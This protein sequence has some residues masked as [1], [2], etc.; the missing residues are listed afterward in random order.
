MTT[1]RSVHGVP[2]EWETLPAL[3]AARAAQHGDL[4]RLTVAGRAMSYRELDDESSLVAANLHRLGVR[5]GDRIACFLRNAPEHLVSWV[6]AGKLG[7]IWVPLNAGLVGEDLVHTL[8][9]AVPAVLVVDE[10]LADRVAAVKEKLPPMRI[11]QTGE[12]KD[13]PA[14]AEL[15]E[16]GAAL[17]MVEV[18]GGDPAVIIYTGGTTGLPKG[19]LLPHFAWIAAG[20][21]YVEAFETRPDD[22]HYSILTLFHVGG[23]MLGVVGPMVADIPTV[24]DRRFSGS[25]FW[26]RARET[27]ATIVDLIGTMITVL[28][29]QPEGPGDRD[30]RVRV[31]LGVTGQI[32]PTVADR[33]VE[34]FGV[35]FVSVY[36]LTETGGVLIVNNRMDSPKP[37]A[38]G[39]PHGWAEVAILDEGDQPMP[40][41]AI[42]Q[43]AL[44]PRYPH[45]FMS[46][47]FNAPERTLECLS[48]QWLHTGDLGYLDE[49]GFLFFTGRQAHWL[50]R[51]GE[52]ISAYEV[53]SVLSHC[54]GVREVVVVGAP[55]EKG[56]ED[57]KA[58]VIREAGS[59]VAPATIAAWC[60]GRMAAFKIPRFIAFV[61][62]FPRSVTKREI[63]RHKLRELPND[64]VW[65]RERQ[66][67]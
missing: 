18:S 61:D 16:P 17:P 9:N 7:A 15:L 8:A 46:G 30:H 57:V 48:N 50:R 4:P 66:A 31:S 10:E 38:N 37:R 60:E 56:E 22:V 67:G 32:P 42:G 33:F 29:E 47:Y 59:D 3:V 40:P 28:V 1:K 2:V 44:R 34:R 43:I 14:F 54:P 13:R 23:L 20:M 45:I 35:G 58:F 19:A 25:N 51:R 36:S 5:R 27:G 55:S 12:R 62:E 63:E 21:R 24:I 41:G 53:E 11:F 49:D 26:A 52:N 39:L 65:D 6:A 64:R